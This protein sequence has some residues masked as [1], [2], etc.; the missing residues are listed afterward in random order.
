[1]N[2]MF[3]LI[4]FVIFSITFD[5][6]STN[7]ARLFMSAV[8]I[9]FCMCS[10]FSINNRRH[11]KQSFI[12]IWKPFKISYWVIFNSNQKVNICEKYHRLINKTET[13]NGNNRGNHDVLILEIE[14]HNFLEQGPHQQ[15][16][17]CLN[18]LRSRKIIFIYYWCKLSRVI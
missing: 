14:H 15:Q 6:K 8:V 9:R 16:R 10:V 1:M 2:L 7:L 5:I 12:Q 3:G 17:Y 13:F 4:H 11:F 18:Y